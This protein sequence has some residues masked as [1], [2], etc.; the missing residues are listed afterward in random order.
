MKYHGI[1]AFGKGDIDRMLLRDFDTEKEAEKFIK[2]VGFSKYQI[3]NNYN[4]EDWIPCDT[5]I[6][7]QKQLSFAYKKQKSEK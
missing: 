2:L 6:D 7:P 1:V 4:K 5:T 3:T